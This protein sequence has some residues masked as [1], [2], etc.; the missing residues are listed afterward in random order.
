[1]EKLGTLESEVVSHE[2]VD[3][4][5]KV[6]VRTVPG[7]KLPRVVRPWLRGK[8]VEFVDTR[9]FLER[10][11][12]KIPFAQ[13][14][15]T[16][17]NITSRASVT[18][19]ITIDRVVGARSETTGTAQPGTVIR[20]RG[21]CVVNVPGLGGKIESIIVQNLREAYEKLPDVVDEWIQ[22][23]E[24]AMRLGD[25]PRNL[26]SLGPPDAVSR[27]SDATT[28]DAS[29]RARS[30]D[31]T[32]SEGG[33]SFH[34][35]SSF[36]SAR[37][38]A[39]ARGAAAHSVWDV[40]VRREEEERDV[41][42]GTRHP[43]AREPSTPTFALSG[44]PPLSPTYPAA[45]MT[46]TSRAATAGSGLTPHAFQSESPLETPPA[47][48]AAARKE[49]SDAD[50]DSADERAGEAP[51]AARGQPSAGATRASPS[52]SRVATRGSPLV[53]DA[54]TGGKNH[55]S[56]LS[57]VARWC[58]CIQGPPGSPLLDADGDA[59]GSG[60]ISSDPEPEPEPEDRR[61]GADPLSAAWDDD[62]DLR[63]PLTP[64][65][66]TKRRARR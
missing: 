55:G 19:T 60:R 30:I 9:T 63:T 41:S 14:F 62:A 52:D 17:N 48:A 13:R 21:E 38:D 39:D 24:R 32:N 61:A 40:S 27:V 18:G 29:P 28:S 4:R 31:S 50:I 26:V 43:R 22:M 42:L 53:R 33:D 15:K 6:V 45:G 5:V 59:S 25:V 8:E 23:R 2:V 3:G 44:R 1:M 56:A 37:S 51:G 10:D 36:G 20:V 11:R 66:K 16:V 58:C 65:A 54:G 35:A 12:G 64:G 47:V 46:G 7:V 57:A 49:D 34:S